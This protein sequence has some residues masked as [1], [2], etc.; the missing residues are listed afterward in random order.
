[1]LHNVKDFIEDN[2]SLID[3]GDY[4]ELFR[5]AYGGMLPLENNEVAEL[6]IMLNSV[7][8]DTLNVRKELL[9]ELIADLIAD[10]VPP[11]D[12]KYRCYLFGLL[13]KDTNNLYGFSLD[14]SKQ[15][16]LD[17]A[18]NLGITLVKINKSPYYSYDYLVN[19]I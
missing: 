12:S 14:E 19:L 18:L 11:A 5:E 6:V 9:Y 8:V 3:N 13:L 7:G 17:N 16:V 10:S 4:E 15:F 2:I 1:M